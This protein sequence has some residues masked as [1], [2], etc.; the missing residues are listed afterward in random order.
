MHSQDFYSIIIFGVNFVL[1]NLVSVNERETQ[2]LTN[3]I[4]KHARANNQ[5]AMRTLAKSI[6]K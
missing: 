2:R 4:R 3:E 6:L 5:Q 1:I